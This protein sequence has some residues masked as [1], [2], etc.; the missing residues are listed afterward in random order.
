M[1]NS[2]KIILHLK[3]S[4]ASVVDIVEHLG[5]SRQAT[6]RLLNKLLNDGVVKK[7]GSAP[8]VYYSLVDDSTEKVELGHYDI[9]P[10]LKNTIEE[11]FMDILPSGDVL[12][13]WAGF[14]AWCQSRGQDVNK[15]ASQYER[16]TR[17]TGLHKKNG[18]IDG[19]D[20]FRSTFEEVAL[21]KV[22]YVDFYSVEIFGK[23]KLGQLLLF[24]KQSQDTVL[25]DQIIEDIRPAIDFLIRK[26][27]IDGVA[28][29]PPTVKRDR[30]IM[31]RIEKRLDLPVRSVSLVK[32]K[33]PVV[34]PQKTLS[35][36][37]DRIVNAR[38]SILVSDSSEYENIL[39]IDDAVGS[40][41]TL[42]EVAKKIRKKGLC[43]GKI[44]GVAI[45][46]SIKGFDVISEV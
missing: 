46:G 29:I 26:F 8:V 2:E 30:Q 42:N 14:V 39:L 31:K 21:D 20:K 24:A 43:T 13:G 6:H 35:K 22:F 5:I 17:E 15:M 38:D 10:A 19:T 28:F 40:G 4:P 1:N 12:E 23:T 25:M 16:V 34:V 11:R 7:M 36:V 27:N 3:N 45:T 37:E 9:E 33:T 41:A 32:I 18:L 44:I